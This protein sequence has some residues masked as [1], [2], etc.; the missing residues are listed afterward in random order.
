MISVN[1]ITKIYQTRS[2]PHR[3]LDDV[4]FTIDRGQSIG[5]LGRNGAGKSTLL[6][7]VGGVEYP[8]VGHVERGMSLSWPLG[9][10]GG[11]Q[12]TLTGADNARFIAR[13][14]GVAP[15]WMID[16]VEEFAELGKYLRMPVKTYSSGM[17]SRLAFGISLALEFDCYLIDEVTAVGDSRFKERCERALEERRSR[18]SILMI[19]HSVQTL[20][21]H[22]KTGGVLSEGRLTLYDDLE[23]AIMAYESMMQ[24]YETAQSHEV[25]AQSHE[26]T[27]Q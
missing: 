10:G 3:V 2:G 12:S 8:T 16:F 25:T 17:R 19:S 13:I 21:L 18:S 23:D 1:N 26:V 7:I 27:A 20:R 22:C 9:F 6:R 24:T 14:Y 5:I 4:S 11:F 15:D